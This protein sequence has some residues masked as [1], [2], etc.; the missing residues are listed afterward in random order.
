MLNFDDL[1]L[2]EVY[3]ITKMIV[4]TF[5]TN[6]APKNNVASII[7]PSPNIAACPL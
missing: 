3:T 7:R 2:I 5:G 6:S 4:N 1:S